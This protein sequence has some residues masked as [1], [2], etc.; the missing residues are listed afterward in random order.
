MKESRGGRTGNRN[1][2][3]VGTGGGGRTGR[4]LFVLPTFKDTTENE[5]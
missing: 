5:K 3:S 4:F 2:G 1:V